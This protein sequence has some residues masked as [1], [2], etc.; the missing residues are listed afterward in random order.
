MRKLV[1]VLTGA[2]VGL[3]GLLASAA[4]AQTTGASGPIVVGGQQVARSPVVSGN[5][6][7][8]AFTGSSH[9]LT[10]VLIGLGLVVLGLLVVVAT[11]RRAQVLQRA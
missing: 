10:Y 8:L 5:S 11:R 1:V 2:M 9:L 6:S 4:S 7:S 3:V